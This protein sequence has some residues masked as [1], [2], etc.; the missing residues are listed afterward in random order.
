MTFIALP[1]CFKPTPTREEL[2]AGIAEQ[3]LRINEKLLAERAER[4]KK[5]R[6]AA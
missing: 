3:A 2:L 1:G 4:P 5:K 6:R